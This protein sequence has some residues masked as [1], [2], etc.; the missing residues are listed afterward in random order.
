MI[1]LATTRLS[2]AS[3]A[4]FGQIH[5]D[6]TFFGEKYSKYGRIGSCPDKK[7]LRLSRIKLDQASPTITRSPSSYIL[8]YSSREL[9]STKY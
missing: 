1:I 6:P 7:T 2:L 3:A 8:S 5:A 9:Y 4:I